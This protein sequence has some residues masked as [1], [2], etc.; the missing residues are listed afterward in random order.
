MSHSE[1]RDGQGKHP[2][3]SALGGIL[4]LS[5]LFY[6]NFVSRV[7]FSPLLPVIEEEMG[8]NHTRSGSLFLFLSVGYFLSI[9]ASGFV[10]ARLGHKRSIVL[11][12][13]GLGMVL[14]VLGSC[15]T[16]L[17][18][19]L[20]L[21][22][23]GIAAGLYFPSG[24]ATISSLVPTSYLARGIAV[25]ELAPNAAFVTAP[26]LCDLFLLH[27]S[28]RAGLALLGV[29]LIVCGIAYGLSSHGCTDRGRAPDLGALVSFLRMPAFWGMILLFS[30]AI[31][32][33]HGIYS[34]APLFLVNDHGMDLE[35][36]NSLLAIS[37]LSS[38]F[39]PLAGGW[40]ADRFGQQRI[41]GLVLLLT[42]LCT[43]MMGL[44]ESR[45]WL[46]TFVVAQPLFAVCFFSAGFAVLS[47]LGANQFGNLAVTLCLPFAFLLGA[48]VMP[49]LIGWIGD[50]IS[51]SSGF[52]IMG[53]F[54]TISGAG[55][56]VITR[57][58]R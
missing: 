58:Q 12:C 6:L 57:K 26:L 53:V 42:G 4:F 45:A 35:G 8:L 30:L 16:L 22:G 14:L 32:A 29:L 52:V 40:I 24:L 7:I 33:T 46:V 54:M 15:S 9:L 23:I 2:L 38:I 31:G 17:G 19:R 47:R 10:A 39:M 56:Y 5:G 20:G 36:A 27:L 25:H 48:G 34:M 21:F 11:S 41:M 18:L 49:T 50:S 37:R 1:N 28:W 3:S 43:L 44:V 55:S 13:V 51:I